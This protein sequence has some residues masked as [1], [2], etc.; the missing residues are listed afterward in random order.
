M[1]FGVVLCP[2]ETLHVFD[3]LH[4]V[5]NLI[6]ICNHPQL[7]IGITESEACDQYVP[8][9]STVADGNDMH[10]RKRGWGSRVEFEHK[11]ARGGG[12][13]V[14]EGVEFTGRLYYALRLSRSKLP[15]VY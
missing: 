4:G 12:D 6:F 3:F 13:L 14:K 1:R 2:D 9:F 5:H 15:K 10:V 7:M 11:K 8:K